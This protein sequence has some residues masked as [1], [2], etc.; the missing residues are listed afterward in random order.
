K[1][2]TSI[3]SSRGC[4]Y[5]CRFCCNQ[6][7]A[8]SRWRPRSVDNTLEELLYLTSAGYQQFVF[9][10]DSFT[11]S[12]KR[13]INLCKRIRQEKLDIEWMCE[14]RVDNCSYEMLKELPKAGCKLI[15]FGIESANQRLLNYYN[16]KITPQQSENAIKTARKAR[17]DMIIGSFIVGAL[18]ETREELRNTFKFAKQLPIDFPQFHILKSYPGT[19]IWDELTMKG[20][21]NE[22]DYWETGVFV[23]KLGSSAVPFHEIRQMAYNALSD[24]I[25]R[26]SFLVRQV[27]L[28][29]KSPYRKSILRTNWKQLG[30]IRE[31]IRSV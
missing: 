5:N 3:V 21:L 26:P 7:L 9:V 28:L 1:K 25:F 11:L 22:E 18:D 14:G 6:K 10:D 16:K 24:F 27:A 4:P 29:L 2:F 30:N 23:S 19:D 15:Y 20:L 12:Q 17:I 13:V 8:R 31:E